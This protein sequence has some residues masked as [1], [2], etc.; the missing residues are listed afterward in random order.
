MIKFLFGRFFLKYLLVNIIYNLKNTCGYKKPKIIY[1]DKFY[2]FIENKV[3]LISLTNLKEDEETF[4]YDDNYIATFNNIKKLEVQYIF[5]INSSI[6][7]SKIEYDFKYMLVSDIS[8]FGLIFNVYVI[9]INFLE[10][11]LKTINFN[12]LKKKIIVS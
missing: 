1:Q 5:K 12:F 7:I 2:S 11:F 10:F 3:I 9:L 8:P 4:I 6:S